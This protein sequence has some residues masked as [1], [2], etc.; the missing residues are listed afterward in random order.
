MS[1]FNEDIIKNEEDII[2]Q[3]IYEDIMS[4]MFQASNEIQK[5]TS[6]GHASWIVT[7]VPVVMHPEKVFVINADGA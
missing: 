7:G 4:K 2:R 1:V 5:R 6:H 3:K